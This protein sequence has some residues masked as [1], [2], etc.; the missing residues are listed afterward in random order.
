MSHDAAV[1][2]IGAQLTEAGLRALA[3]GASSMPAVAALPPA[4][5]EEVS[6][7]AAAAF[8]TEAS[9]V[10]TAHA[11]AQQELLRAGAALVEISSIYEQ[12][13][14]TAAGTLATAGNQLTGEAFAA[15]AGGVGAA[16]ASAEAVPLPALGT[17]LMTSL[18]EGVTAASASGSLPAAATAATTVL[19]AGT[20][21][22]SSL[23]SLT[24]MG[25]MGGAA[26]GAAGGGAAAVPT[27]L[28]GDKEN[29]PDDTQGQQADGSQG[30]QASGKQPGE[31]LL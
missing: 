23:S 11:A 20:A 3:A 19:S 28:A 25:G 2:A 22:L 13:D 16:L 30:Q 27:T 24:S 6:A 5:A 17:P 18:I 8:A 1:A 4:G 14:V 12:A 21:P 26:G 10:L 9:A 15:T 29:K 7:Q 31:T